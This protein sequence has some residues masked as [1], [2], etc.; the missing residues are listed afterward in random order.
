MNAS[1]TFARLSILIAAACA[2]TPLVAQDEAS[3]PETQQITIAT[4]HVPPFAIRPAAEGGPWTGLTMELWSAIAR[5]LNLD[6]EFVE[7]DL[8]EMVVGVAERRYDA[9]VA[10][11]TMTA[12]RE[13]DIDFS[14]PFYTAGLGIA[15]SKSRGDW[16][17]AVRGIFTWRLAQAVGTL[18]FILLVVGA[19]V[20]MVENR[21]N[22]DEFG[23]PWWQGLGNGF[24]WSA[25]TMTT[26]GYGDKSP[27]SL[28]GRLV[29]LVWMFASI[30]IISGMTAAI[31]SAL[32]VSQLGSRISGPADLPG[33]TVAT[34][35]GSTA[36][37]YLR[38][39]NVRVVAVE[40]PRAALD[41]LAGERV[42]AAVYDKPILQYLLSQAGRPDLFVL[43]VTFEEQ[44]YAIGLPEQDP[45]REPL[46]RALLEHLA[47]PEWRQ[48]INRYL[49][50]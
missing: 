13:R 36:E 9:A 26:V 3:T 8:D 32:T 31:A 37:Q 14:Y 10:A 4:R 11:L 1:S 39:R 43:P 40:S 42:D 16:L 48:N 15:V 35:S 49:G 46:N 23:G 5:A 19:F 34:V 25:V 44:S 30:I 20:W 47:S 7:T 18:S 50:E 2:T 12:D 29:A 41:A 45:L 38:A 28:L 17:G 24:W 27:R 21:K 33:L 22:K 6:A